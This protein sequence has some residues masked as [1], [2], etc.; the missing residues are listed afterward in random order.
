M[1]TKGNYIQKER[2]T[3]KIGKKIANEVTNKGLNVQN[4]QTT[5]AAQYQKKKKTQSKMDRRSKQT[6]LQR[7]H[8]GDQRHMKRCLRSLIIREM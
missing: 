5:H 8:T 1:H 2:I 6:F 7:R 3:Q 4:I